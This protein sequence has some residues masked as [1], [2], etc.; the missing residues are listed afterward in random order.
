MGECGIRRKNVVI[1]NMRRHLTPG[2]GE[3]GGQQELRAWGRLTLEGA[4]T[5]LLRGSHDLFLP[6][7]WVCLLKL[8]L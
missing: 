8:P 6:I 1:C 5:V 3:E 7:P 2:G 4:H